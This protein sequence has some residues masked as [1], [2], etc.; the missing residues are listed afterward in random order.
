MERVSEW[1]GWALCVSAPS[2]AAEAIREEWWWPLFKQ[3]FTAE[4]RKKARWAVPAL[5]D[6]LRA[7]NEPYLT[8]KAALLWIRDHV[9]S[10]SSL[11][12][13]REA[14]SVANWLV[15]CQGVDEGILGS[16]AV[17]DVLSKL[18]K[19]YDTDHKTDRVLLTEDMVKG[20]AKGKPPRLVHLLYWQSYDQGK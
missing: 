9:C 8:P 10:E 18:K 12:I 17:R 20:F 13:V 6:W 4:T 15:H 5:A 1:E 16:V 11:N 7:T 19:R 3:K 14:L 2:A